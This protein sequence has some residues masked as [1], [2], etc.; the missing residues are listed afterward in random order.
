MASALT[1]AASAAVS[2]FPVSTPPQELGT[3]TI[4]G[5]KYK[6]TLE[7]R[8]IDSS[9]LAETL[10]KIHMIAKTQLQGVTGNVT[11]M[12]ITSN[13]TTFSKTGTADESKANTLNVADFTSDDAFT[14][15]KFQASGLSTT[16]TP[17]N[18]SSYNSLKASLTGTTDLTCSD[19]FNSIFPR[20]PSSSSGGSLLGTV[21]GGGG[22]SLLAGDLGSTTSRIGRSESPGRERPRSGSADGLGLVG[23]LGSAPANLSGANRPLASVLAS[24]LSRES[25]RLLLTPSSISARS[26]LLPGSTIAL[27]LTAADDDV[28]SRSSTSPLG[29]ADLPRSRAGSDAST[30]TTASD[31]DEDD[32]STVGSRSRSG[33]IVG[34][35]AD[36]GF[37]LEA[38]GGSLPLG[39][40]DE[41]TGLA[42]GLNA[43]SLVRRTGA[44]GIGGSVDGS[45]L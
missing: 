35:D 23:H 30:A 29:H 32:A 43:G 20:A 44:S 26:L 7:N 42:D 3:L 36:L 39:G 14:N 2:L 15:D 31:E 18:F 37:R 45:G 40:A 9:N 28:G 12:T 25:A 11:Q 34:D 24:S 13:Q 10:Q 33:S 41:L 16:E 5:K 21:G 1:S 8:R 27:R 17:I 4:N 19:V 38:A 22:G 6:V